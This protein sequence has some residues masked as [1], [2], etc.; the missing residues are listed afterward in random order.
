MKA[1][2]LVEAA[3]KI[4]DLR[5]DAREKAELVD[6]IGVF[7]AA[8]TP[9]DIIR[10]KSVAFALVGGDD[11]LRVYANTGP[12]LAMTLLVSAEKPDTLVVSDIS[13]LRE[14]ARNPEWANG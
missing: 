3:D 10:R 11:E 2:F 1:S 12:L 8:E 14:V 7:Q 5:L 4:K 13:R 6:T 9:E